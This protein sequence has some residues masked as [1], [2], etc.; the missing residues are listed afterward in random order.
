MPG[1]F[2]NMDAGDLE[3]RV[4]FYLN[5][6]TASFYTQTEIWAWLT[7][8]AKDIA[9]KTTCIRRVLDSQ[10]ANGVRTVLFNAYKVFHVEYIPSSGR[11]LMLT[12]I[13]PLRVGHYPLD[14]TTPQYWYEY[15]S[16]IGIEPLPDAVYNLRL[17]ISDIP[18]MTAFTFSGFPSGWTSGTGWVTGSNGAVHSGAIGTLIYATTS[19]DANNNYTLSFTISGTGAGGTLTPSIGSSIGVPVTSNGYH[20]Q[21]II[22]SSGSPA[23]A[24][25]ATNAITIN[26]LFVFKEAD[27]T[28]VSDQ[29]EMPVAFQ[30]LLALHAAY[31][32]LM[33][34]KSISPAQML[35][36][37]YEGELSYLR[38]NMV[39]VIPNG[40][41]SQVYQ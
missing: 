34:N 14:G 25:V 28:S 1:T 31:K 4:R 24:L 15:G 41:D 32:G 39:E 36:T 12:K 27:F 8:A 7:M 26:D 6:V 29:T 37:I 16:S 13:D 19:L 30:N 21:N 38:Q 20:T 3:T 18:K 23:L 2:P 5:E 9:Q 33:K 10:T 40:K 35:N 11:P 17:Y 22:S